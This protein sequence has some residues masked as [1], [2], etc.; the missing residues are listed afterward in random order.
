MTLDNTAFDVPKVP[1]VC[2]SLHG[3]AKT[4]PTQFHIYCT[5]C[6]HLYLLFTAGVE[7]V[8]WFTDLSWQ[9]NIHVQEFF[10]RG[11]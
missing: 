9:G 3:F 1:H 11:R 8:L 2:T 4:R 6:S 7:S 10:A 5:G